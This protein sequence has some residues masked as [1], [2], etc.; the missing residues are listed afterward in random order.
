MT[1]LRPK[2]KWRISEQN[3]GYKIKLADMKSKWRILNQNGGYKTKTADIKS[4]W[5]IW[6]QS[7][8][9]EIKMADILPKRRILNSHVL[10][11]ARNNTQEIN[12][13]ITEVLMRGG[14]PHH[15]HLIN[16]SQNDHL[17]KFFPQWG[18]G[19]ILN[20]HMINWQSWPSIKCQS[21]LFKKILLLIT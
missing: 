14:V 8:G 6:N 5:W 3:G 10:R 9:Y 13:Q 12:N 15:P 19:E 16:R 21:W 2:S 1:D 20:V 11:D 7:G 17:F 4:N 18:G